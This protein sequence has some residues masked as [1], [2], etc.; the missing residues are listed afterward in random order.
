MMSA[1][2][3]RRKA[4]AVAGTLALLFV[5]ATPGVAPPGDL[6][7]TFDGDGAPITS[8]NASATQ[9]TNYLSKTALAR[10]T[11]PFI[12]NRGQVDARVAYYA[13]TLAGTVHVTRQGLIVHSLPA[14]GSGKS[15][16]AEYGRRPS[17]GWTLTQRLVTSAAL[18]PQA[19]GAGAAR[20]NYFLGKDPARWQR[21]LPTHDRISL[22][23]AWP[24]IGVSL[25]AHGDRVETFYTLAPGAEVRR[26]RVAVSGA[27]RLTHQDGR[28]V[29]RTGL[30][31]VT[32]SMPQAWQVIDGARRS[33]PVRY[34]LQETNYGFRLGPHDPAV[35]VVIDPDI[36]A[37]YLGGSGG[38]FA[39]ALALDAGGDVYV[40]GATG[41]ANFP[42]TTSG[43]QPTYT[44]GQ[45]VFVARLNPELTTLDQATYLGGGPNSLGGAGNNV[46]YALALGGGGVYVAG[47]TTSTDFPG[48]TGGAQLIHGGSFFNDAF[49]AKLNPALTTLD[50]ATFLGGAVNDAAYGLALDAGG[51]VYVAGTTLSLNFPGT[52]GG[53]QPT[54]AGTADAFLAKLN[55]GLTT[56]AQATY[57]GGS[58]GVDAGSIATTAGNALALGVGAEVY[59][60]GTTSATNFPGTAGGA[61]E[62]HGGR[63]NDAFVA[64]LNPG[65]TVLD[66]A[67]YLGGSGN[68][69]E[70]ANA[71]AIDGG[72]DVYVAGFTFSINFPGTAGGAQ[73]TNGGGPDDTFIARLNP[74]LTTIHQATYLG[75]SNIDQTR[76]LAL[77]AGGEVYVA[78][79]TYSPNFPATAG[80]VQPTSGGGSNDAFVARLNAGLTTLDQATYLG[81][82]GI[83][84]G[85]ALALAPGGDVYVAGSTYAPSSDFPGTTGGAQP[86][87]A[88]SFDAYAAKLP[89]DLKAHDAV[90]LPPVAADDSVTTPQGLPKTINVLAN[91]SDPDGDPLTVTGVTDPPNGTATINPDNTVTYR[92]ECGFL[93]TDTFTYT[94]DDGRSGT[95]T[96]VVTVRV[97]KTSRRGSIPGC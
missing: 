62:T 65:L 37:T 92:P 33:I 88:G 82:S 9:T 15:P 31:P 41:S 96:G 51:N 74:G 50:Q 95:D 85:Y 72:G 19:E 12:S 26:I 25:T 52:V 6:D 54:R 16:L 77:T 27:E 36:Q 21:N 71:L 69:D 86:T 97:R 44:G 66:Q 10:L 3:S 17:P 22:G 94:I 35:P 47:L 60:A 39:Y 73:A 83:N 79:T 43:A 81:G 46:A 78:G 55:S 56:L 1:I 8:S 67:T 45:N 4:L 23:E 59:V 84:E 48:T 80:G 11:L 53:A 42:G 75:G 87:S 32:L 24:G 93:G 7:P 64:R 89:A 40:A 13:S 70:P 28:L 14:R 68:G 38:D 20:V 90:N 76:A 29:A 30:G 34:V 49:V 63:P 91:D 2:A 61:Q 57:L 5:L 58:V 18:T